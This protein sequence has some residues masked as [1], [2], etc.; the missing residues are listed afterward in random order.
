MAVGFVFTNY[1]LAALVGF[2]L[3]TRVW[4]ISNIDTCWQYGQ[5]KRRLFP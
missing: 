1:V 2:V 5:R 4:A 3:L